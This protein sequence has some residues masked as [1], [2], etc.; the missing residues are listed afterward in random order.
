MNNFCPLISL[1]P[2]IRAGYY[3]VFNAYRAFCLVPLLIVACSDN[4]QLQA[5]DINATVLAF[6]DSLTYGTG[7]SRD[8]AYPAILQTLIRRKV[9]N[10][11]IPGETSEQGLRRLPAL[12]DA[13]HPDLIIIC[14]GGNDILRKLDLSKTQKNIQQMID[15]ARHN[16][17]EVILIAV[18]AFNLFLSKVAIYQSLANDNNI[19]IEDNSLAKILASN[20]LK[21]DYIHPNSTGY[22]QLA[23][24]I[25]QLLKRYWAITNDSRLLDS[26]QINEQI[27][28]F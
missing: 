21:S 17:T 16:N 26:R 13:Y 5:L 10:V 19:P 1:N 25:S 14:H 27:D 23:E 3:A 22:Q 28:I 2:A 18:P 6:G 7:T 12:L 4:T 9:I 11:G 8:K 20:A 24:D 15:L